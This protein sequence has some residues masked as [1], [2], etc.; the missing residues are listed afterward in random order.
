MDEFTTDS[1]FA[2]EVAGISFSKKLKP[3]DIVLLTGELGAGKT[4]FVQGVAKGLNIKSRV[5][6]PTFVLVRKHRGKIDKKKINLYHIDL[7]R[8]ENPS[9]IKNLGLEDIFEDISGI[10]LIE[11]GRKHEYLK[12]TWE[13]SIEI[14]NGK[15]KINIK[16][17]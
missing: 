17:E 12:F 9:E 8:L 7:Y 13:V 6:S 15:R 16:D 2:T 5:I 4:V 14:S 3:G 10:F 11:W 1:A